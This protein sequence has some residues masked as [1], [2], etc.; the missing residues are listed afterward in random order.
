MFYKTKNGA[1][2]A[3]IIQS[4]IYTA[5]ASGVNVQ[6]W[7]LKILESADAVERDPESF[8]PWKMALTPF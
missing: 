5:K 3:G 7:L 2:V 1:Y 6:K 4:M 8:F